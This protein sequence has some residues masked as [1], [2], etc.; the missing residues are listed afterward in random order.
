MRSKYG[1]RSRAPVLSVSLNCE[2][3]GFLPY[4]ST[5]RPC[6]EEFHCCWTEYQAAG[7]RVF[8]A[9]GTVMEVT[10]S[11]TDAHRILYLLF[12]GM[13]KTYLSQMAWNTKATKKK[14]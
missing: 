2:I 13:K 3:P 14:E 8:S 11:A 7:R 10:V 4:W 6:M 9:K 5:D 12:C 1:F